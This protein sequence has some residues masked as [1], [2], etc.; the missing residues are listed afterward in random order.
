MLPKDLLKKIRRIELIAKKMSAEILAGEYSSAFKGQGLEFAQVREYVYGDDIRNIDWNV[1]SRN[2]KLFIKEFAEERELNVMLLIDLSASGNFYSGDLSKR[3]LLATVSALLAFSATINNDNVGAILF[4][5][6]IELYIPPDKGKVH[7]L[8]IIREILQFKPESRGTSINEGLVYF[9]RVI[10]KKTICFLFSDFIDKG[11]EQSLKIAAQ[12]H[13]LVAVKIA[14]PLEK[15][16]L[17]KGIYAFKDIES[18]KNYRVDLSSDLKRN[19]I[20]KMKRDK[21]ER[22]KNFFKSNKVDSIILDTKSDYEKKVLDFFK[23]RKRRL[24]S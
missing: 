14:D 1:T 7:L 12:K 22:D 20:N 11:Y 2:A 3:E 5:D 4:S 19:L 15:E 24:K 13:D 9:N 6:K 10:K 16:L 18:G 21:E 23:K 17:P 8:R